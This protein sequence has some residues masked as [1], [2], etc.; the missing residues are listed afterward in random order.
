M[1]AFGDLMDKPAIGESDIY[2]E[3]LYA[4]IRFGKVPDDN[5]TMS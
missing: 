4:F 5:D 2:E 3:S 1:P